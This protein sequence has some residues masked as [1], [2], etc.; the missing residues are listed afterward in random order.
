VAI[1]QEQFD[2]L[3]ARLEG[4]AARRPLWYKTRVFLLAMLGYAYVFG[5]LAAIL[6]IIAAVVLMVST[7]RGI[8]LVKN[9]AIPLAIFAWVVGK[10]LWVKLEPPSGRRLRREEAPR[11]FAAMDDICKKIDAPRAHVVLLDDEFNAAVSQVPRLGVF[12]WHRNYLIVGLPLMQAL[13]PDEWRGVLAHEF[14]HLSRAHARFSNW[15]YRV[16]KS[17]F[18]LMH[19]LEEDRKSGGVWLFKR[20]FHWY[21]PYFGAYSFVLARRDEFEADRLAATVVGREAM[22]RGFITGSLRNRALSERFW[23]AIEREITTRPVPPDDVHSRMAH[24]LRGELEWAPV[25]NWVADDLAVETGS[26]DTHP[27][28]RDR[29]AALGVDVDELLITGGSPAEPLETTA[30]EYFLGNLATEATNAFDAVWR[31]RAEEWW[32][33]RHERERA[34]EATLA[35]LEQRTDALGDDELWELAH[36]TDSRRGADAAEPHYRELLTRIPTHAG[37]SY[38]LGINLLRRDDAEG[39]AHIERAIAVDADATAPGS[40]TIA[41]WLRHV[42]RG[43]EAELYE[44]RAAEADTIKAEAAHERDG[45]YRQDSFLPH[46]LDDVELAEVRTA[47]ARFSHEL[48]RAWLVRK[49]VKHHPDRGVFVIG[50]EL[51]SSVRAFLN[52][53]GFPVDDDPTTGQYVQAIA[54]AVHIPCFVVPLRG[55]NAWV[56]KKIKQVAGAMIYERGMRTEDRGKGSSIGPGAPGAEPPSSALGPR[57]SRSSP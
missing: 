57:S 29:I 28:H 51:G 2:T 41:H 6:G 14:S 48:K 37:A 55:E 47:L 16:R 12:G 40:R 22:A 30:A 34:E 44:A 52:A 9:V 1:T 39:I 11:L 50:V 33:E 7:G 27:C 35:A 36:L 15:I 56:R 5:I 32:R 31:Q 23:P 4:E 17:W 18:Q 10:S 43:D 45:V 21:A 25:K 26:A 53:R 3:V 42:G 38:A 46:A 49:A 20:F 54:D 19:T 13:P 8:I 24:A